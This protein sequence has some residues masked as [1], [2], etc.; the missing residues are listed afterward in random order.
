MGR[1]LDLTEQL[2]LR[3]TTGDMARLNKVAA[4]TPALPRALIGRQ[5]LRLGLQ[6]FG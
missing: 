3:L 5:A 6:L 4:A 1:D 2:M